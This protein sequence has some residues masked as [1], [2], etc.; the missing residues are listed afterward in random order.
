[1]LI[2]YARTS[3]RDQAAGFEVQLAT[4]RS[5]GCEKIFSEQVSSRAERAQL[6]LAL[7]FIREGDTFVVTKL[8]R[9]ARSLKDLQDIQDVLQRKKVGLHILAM[10][11]QTSTPTGKLLWQIVGAIAEFEREMMLERQIDGVRA[12]KAAGKFRGRKP[13]AML[14]A[15]AISKL[16]D[17]GHTAD[18]IA[19]ELGIHR[20]SV[21]RVLRSPDPESIT[22]RWL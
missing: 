12:A 11:L 19:C 8:D 6:S 3:T 20:T 10:G 14:Q 13:T 2:G 4:L 7:E 17:A 18:D 9:L 15:S 21:Y 1:M 16:R 5:H 22:R